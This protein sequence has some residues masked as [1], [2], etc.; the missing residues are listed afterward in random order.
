ME[1]LD[2]VWY[3]LR[4]ENQS[5]NVHPEHFHKAV[6]HGFSLLEAGMPRSLLQTMSAGFLL[7][8]CPDAAAGY[9]HVLL[10]AVCHGL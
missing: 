10:Q 9:D 5:R 6:A 3:P 1:I 8:G 2:E 4:M 7:R